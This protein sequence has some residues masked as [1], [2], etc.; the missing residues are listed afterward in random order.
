VVESI[1]LLAATRGNPAN[2]NTIKENRG[3]SRSARARSER[4]LIVGVDFG[5]SA[6]KVVWQDLTDNHFEAFRWPEASTK[7]TSLLLPSTVTFRAGAVYFGLLDSDHLQ[8]DVQLR[9]IKLCVLCRGVLSICRCGNA[10]ATEG[11]IRFPGSTQSISAG[12][13]ACLFLGYVFR[14]VELALATKFPNDNLLLLWN[15]GCPMDHLD[16]GNR[17]S[18]W[19]KMAGVGMKL[20][21][22]VVN[23]VGLH[24]A[25][26][27]SKTMETIVVPAQSDRNYFVQPE[28]F[29]AVKAFLESPQGESKTYAIVDIGAGTTEVSFLFNGG[30]WRRRAN[31]SNPPT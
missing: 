2:P 5:T 20:R 13:I 15:V 18:A 8:D 7:T 6:T 30:R 11:V 9:S 3:Q 28:G 14:E 25:S 27:A 21:A 29:A 26:E 22:R 12:A 31:R 4:T 23:P 10:G 19:E 24:L 17:K 16:D 1:I